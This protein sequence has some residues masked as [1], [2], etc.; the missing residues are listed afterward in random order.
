[1]S[2]P[3]F[4]QVQYCWGTPPFPCQYLQNEAF[5]DGSIWTFTNGSYQGTLTDQC[6]W[7]GGTTGAGVLANGGSIY[8]DFTATQHGSFD[9]SFD[10]YFASSGATNYDQLTVTVKNLDNN[11]QEVF[12]ISGAQVNGQCA[13]RVTFSPQNN[14]YGADVRVTFYR[15]VLSSVGMSIDNVTMW[16][17]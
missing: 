1:M 12:Y 8:Q 14:Y 7:G 2:V 10:L 4:A 11:T 5:S 3:A 9:L 17:R 6:A 16:S 13:G 15:A